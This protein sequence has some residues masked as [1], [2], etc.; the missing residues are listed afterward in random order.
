MCYSL[1]L[2]H[3]P[4]V[5]LIGHAFDLIGVTNPAAILLVTVPCCIA[6]SVLIAWMFHRLVERRFWNPRV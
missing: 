6:V 2:V 5:A 1:Y 3:W 4:V